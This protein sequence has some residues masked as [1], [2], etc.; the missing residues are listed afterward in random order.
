MKKKILFV[1]SLCTLFSV[2][3]AQDITISSSNEELELKF[4]WAK[5][6]A[7]SFITTGQTGPIDGH[8]DNPEGIKKAAYI[9]SYYAG[10]PT[11]TAFYSRD[12]CHQALGAHALGL[13]VENFTM[14]KAFASTA[15]ARRKWFPLW[16]LNFDGSPYKMDYRNDNDFVREVPATFEL[17]EKAYLLYCWTG[18]R[19][20]LEDETLWNYYTKAVTDFV[21]LHDKKFPN[22]VAEG[23]G[24]GNIFKGV[25]T[26][27]EQRDV[28]LIEAGDGIACQYQAFLAF[29]KMAELR[30]Q[31]S[32]AQEFQKKAD[33]LKKYF[34][35]NWGIKNTDSFNRGYSPEKKPVD[36]WGKENSWFMPMKEIVDVE[37]ARTHRY[38][39][40]ID[41]RLD[42]K[43]DIPDNIEAI[44]YIPEIF[45]KYHKNETG[46]K[47]LKYIMETL[48][49]THS[50]NAT[51]GNNGNYPEVSY[52]L[53]SNV[54]ESLVGIRP[55]AGANKVQTI[56]HLPNDIDFLKVRNVSIGDM[57]IAVSHT[58]VNTTRLE[59]NK[60]TETLKW[61]AGFPG[62]Y[63]VLYLDGA[64][65]K[66]EQRK[67]NGQI[68][69]FVQI[70]LKPGEQKEVSIY[71][72]K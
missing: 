61:E 4:E 17:V 39:D 24:E 8:Q 49:R 45:F 67:D 21:S 1:L 63:D 52:V 41:E 44:S 47:W 22:G 18:D 38:L 53:I 64:E 36:G 70:D 57:K 20:Y 30:G 11:R 42:S 71:S 6:K 58:K 23:T 2:A 66:A 51:T 29:S 3:K 50:T 59:Y 55:D 56:S 9:P 10:Y 43:D 14:M 26:F 72:K 68:C 32:L 25:A 65:L 16:A 46:W 40:Y 48:D 5:E 12:Y 28:P 62:Q 15:T 34:N 13:E 27:N 19:K 7:R 37:S 69:S 31:K 60:G 54:V 33:D 35:T